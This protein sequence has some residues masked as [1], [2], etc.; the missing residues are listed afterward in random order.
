MVELSC[1]TL[2][3]IYIQVKPAWAPASV[4]TS[5]FW[6][7]LCAPYPWSRAWN[8]PGKLSEALKSFIMSSSGCRIPILGTDAAQDKVLEEFLD[9][10]KVK[11]ALDQLDKRIKK[12]KKEGHLLRLQLMRLLLLIY[13]DRQLH[14]TMPNVRLQEYILP[15]ITALVSLAP[16]FAADPECIDA[17]EDIACGTWSSTFWKEA[18]E[19]HSQNDQIFEAWF[20]TQVRKEQY[21]EAAKACFIWR[22]SHPQKFHELTWRMIL[23]HFLAS[24]GASV[25]DKQKKMSKLMCATLIKQAVENTPTQNDKVKLALILL[26]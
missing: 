14:A 15:H 9:K 17:V 18:C 2:F 24:M 21:D 22:R 13:R 12:T 7:P 10:N 16:Q 3:Q 20:E 26:S 1:S 6:L 4:L 11:S 25:D 8:T 5:A 23:C 19:A